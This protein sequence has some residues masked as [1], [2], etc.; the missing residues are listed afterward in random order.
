MPYTRYQP[1]QWEDPKPVATKAVPTA[2]VIQVGDLVSQI[3]GDVNAASGYTWT[4]DLPT[5]QTNFHDQFLGV[6]LERSRAGDVLPI[7]VASAGVHEFDCA[8][9][10]FELG[11]LVGPAKASGN[12]LENQKV[13]AVAT[14]ALA[15][16]RVAQR[17][18]TATRVKV[19]VTSGVMFG[20]PV[21][22]G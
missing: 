12:N 5:T 17:A 18:V 13:A 21:V 4:T 6:A 20:G 11:D 7:R 2:N 10:T 8:S 9:A 19:S 1:W 22:M 14:I 16:G 15:I 3:A